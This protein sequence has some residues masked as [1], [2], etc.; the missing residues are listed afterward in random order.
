MGIDR[1]VA[2]ASAGKTQEA[3][4]LAR[5]LREHDIPA[6]EQETGARVDDAKLSLADSVMVERCD[7]ALALDIL[8]NDVTPSVNQQ[9]ATLAESL[10]AKHVDME[11]WRL[12]TEPMRDPLRWDVS[13]SIARLFATR[14]VDPANTP[15]PPAHYVRSR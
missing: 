13:S 7:L 8:A 2:L 15:A 1:V 10:R 6:L 3:R 4:A 11:A 14:D 9:L 12:Q 5:E